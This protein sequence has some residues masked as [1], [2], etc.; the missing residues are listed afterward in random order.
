VYLLHSF[1]VKSSHLNFIAFSSGDVGG[2]DNDNNNDRDIHVPL[3]IFES[4]IHTHPT[5][6]HDSEEERL[7][8]SSQLYHPY[9]PFSS[10][11]EE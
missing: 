2:D 3:L 8:Q 9:T 7:M 1:F 6:E 4:I 11:V 10:K 5:F